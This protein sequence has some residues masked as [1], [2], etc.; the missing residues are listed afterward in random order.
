MDFLSKLDIKR[1]GPLFYDDYDLEQWTLE[2]STDSNAGDLGFTLFGPVGNEL[3]T[4]NVTRTR[5]GEGDTITVNSS[6]AKIK[7]NPDSDGFHG[8]F[9][10]RRKKIESEKLF[11]L[12]F[13]FRWL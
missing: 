9:L 3:Y 4:R 7:F 5:D 6:I 12:F 1:R 8:R 13:W 2:W 11:P 10:V